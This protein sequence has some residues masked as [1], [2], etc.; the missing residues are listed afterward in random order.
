MGYIFRRGQQWFSEVRRETVLKIFILTT[1]RKMKEFLESTGFCH[2]WIPRFAEMS[3]SLYEAKKESQP[4]L[5]TESEDKA[6]NKI[7]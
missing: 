7:K 6:F 5:W 4:F 2:L 1:M 3:T